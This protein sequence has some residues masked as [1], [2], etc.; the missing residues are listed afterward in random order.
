MQGQP[1]LTVRQVLNKPLTSRRLFTLSSSPAWTIAMKSCPEY[2]AKLWTDF[3]I[4]QLCCKSSHPRRALAAHHPNPQPPPLALSQVLHVI[5]R[6]S[7]SPS[8]LF[9]PLLHSTYLIS[10]TPTP[11]PRIYVF[12]FPPACELLGTELSL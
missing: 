6:W 9:M 7:P 11:C 1:V 2:P 4:A 10:F 12:C 3:S 8:N 5:Q